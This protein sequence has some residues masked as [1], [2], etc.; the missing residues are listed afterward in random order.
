MAGENLL[1]KSCSS[2]CCPVNGCGLGFK[3]HACNRRNKISRSG[4]DESLNHVE[5]RPRRHVVTRKSIPGV[6]VRGGE[7]RRGEVRRLRALVGS[8]FLLRGSRGRLVL[9]RFP[10]RTLERSRRPKARGAID[11]SVDADCSNLNARRETAC[12]T[13]QCQEE[14]SSM[15]T[16]VGGHAV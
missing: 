8:C 12:V 1:E 16:K 13:C 9:A 14:R 15:L 7:T 2:S 4:G 5:G 10:R 11:V 3:G 6:L